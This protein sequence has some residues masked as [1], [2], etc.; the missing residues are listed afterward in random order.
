[1]LINFSNLASIQ[2]AHNSK[3]IKFFYQSYCNVVILLF[4]LFAGLLLIS[5]CAAKTDRTFAQRTGELSVE[6]EGFRNDKGEVIISLFTVD[7]GFPNNMERAWQN[8][9][10]KIESGRA[11]VLIA[12][13][14]YG[15][16]AMS[17]LHDEDGD[18]QMKSGWLGKPLE[19]F[20]FSG[21]PEYTFGPPAFSDAS[22]L[23]VSA[24]REI[25][26]R[27]RYDTK[28]KKNR[29]ERRSAQDGKGAG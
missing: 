5:G 10:V 15:E 21:S 1:M 26:A 16:Y 20:G 11:H 19:G 8:Q 17:F 27:V 13:V 14:P 25:V 23:L 3:D 6:I 9:Q 24:K 12:D 22:F 2:D 18:Q 29:G 4:C 28:C 7:G